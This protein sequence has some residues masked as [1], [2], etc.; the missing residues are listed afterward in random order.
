MHKIQIAESVLRRIEARRGTRDLLEG[1]LGPS[2]A[3]IVVDLQNAYMLPGMAAEVPIA[4]ELVPNVNLL[5]K[6]TRNAGGKVVWLKMTYSGQ[7]HSWSV[8]F[9]FIANPRHRRAQLEALS[10]GN[11]GHEI[12]AHLDV[13][14]TDLVVEKRRFSPFVPGSSDLDSVLRSFGIETLIITGTVTNTCCE[15][16]ARDAMMLN[17][18]VAFVSDGNAALSDEE[19]NASLTNIARIFG[20]V[21]ST[22]ELL[23]RFEKDKAAKQNDP[24]TGVSPV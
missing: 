17:Y 24:L 5:A 7:E 20:V 21:L 2:C 22:D 6:A 3:L 4:R 16:T 19:H 18:R 13:Q 11:H 9:D 15:C 10:S 1:Q 14:S 8:F 23:A 12:Y